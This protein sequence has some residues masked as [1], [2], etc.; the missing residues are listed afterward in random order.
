VLLATCASGA[1]ASGSAQAQIAWAP[2]G[3][4]NDFACGH[5]TVPLDPT[6][7]GSTGTTQG[8]ITLAMHRHRSPVGE[9]KD[10]V[11]ALAG[12]PGQAAI[13]LASQ[14]AQ[15]LGPIVAT[16]DLIVFDQ[17]GTGLS[18][19]LSCPAFEHLGSN[20]PSPGAVAICAGQIGEAREHYTTAETV[21][22]IEAIRQAGGYEKLVLYGTSYGTK[23]AERY[24]QAYPS[25]V[26]ALV[27]DS[28]VPPDGP[29]PLDR[30]TFAAIPRV[31]RE[32][33]GLEACAHITRDPVGDLA[34]LVGRM[35]HGPLR[36]RVRAVHGAVHT[37]SITSN[38]LLGILIEGDLDPSLRAG[39]P[40]AVHSALS[41]RTTALARLLAQAE[42]E[43]EGE[44][45]SLAE[46][47]D[48]PLYFTTT[49]EETLFPFDRSAS[50]SRRL[51]EAIAQ[52]V[53]APASSFAPFTAPNAFAL[54]DIPVCSRWP[55][56]TP[57][58]AV[59]KSPLPSVPTLIL[60]G[61]D[62]LRT[63]TSNA[64]ALAAEIPGSHLLVVP[65]TGHSVLGSDLTSCAHDALEALFANRPI[66]AC[67]K[68][69]PPPYLR[70]TPL[71]AEAAR[72]VMPAAS[73]RSGKLPIT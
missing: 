47:F 14:F 37:L 42:S 25:H 8:V 10:A 45:E 33:C 64:R 54:S 34:R 63:P 9:A 27:L 20:G 60:S 16:R 5:L 62:D 1:L 44:P 22:D 41:G 18:H 59:D 39:F 21:A 2:C 6:D 69:P 3:D 56:L 73:R 24:A 70:P 23:V 66:R 15:V 65:N 58:P 28:V 72:I 31:L 19:P 55:Y 53:A 17:R 51:R 67:P 11:I 12:G 26:E 7:Q 30:S 36:G 32:L 35:R 61:A 4:S 29:D 43:S 13:P 38:D 50:P 71:A 46:G 49:C 68:A 40:A 57:A 48:W 52:I